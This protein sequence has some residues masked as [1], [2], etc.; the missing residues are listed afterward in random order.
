MSKVQVEFAAELEGG[1]DIVQAA[2][3]DVIGADALRHVTKRGADGK[4]F[5][6]YAVLDDAETRHAQIMQRDDDHR[7]ECEILGAFIGRLDAAAAADLQHDVVRLAGEGCALKA[8]VAGR[9]GTSAASAVPQAATD[10][11]LTD[12]EASAFSI[13]I[14][15][16]RVRSRDTLVQRAA[17]FWRSPFRSRLVVQP[18]RSLHWRCTRLRW[19]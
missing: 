3:F 17:T 19:H 13:S 11:A 1:V 10:S 9:G 16:V 12:Q 2:Q 5:L 14:A 8:G 6:L 15:G 7:A 18:Y 4:T